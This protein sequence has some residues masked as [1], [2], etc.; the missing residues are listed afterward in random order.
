MTRTRQTSLQVISSAAVTTL[1]SG[2]VSACY[3]HLDPAVAM[4]S[5]P[6]GTMQQLPLNLSP[7]ASM[8]GP[9]A[10]LVPPNLDRLGQTRP[11][12]FGEGR[13]EMLPNPFAVGGTRYGHEYTGWVDV[14]S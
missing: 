14:R 5:G 8:V 2:V 9:G 4:R 11:T 7:A 6:I 3:I 10:V 1:F 13:L 12:M